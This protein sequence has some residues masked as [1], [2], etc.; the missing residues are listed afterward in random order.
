MSDD[1]SLTSKIKT[2]EDREDLRNKVPKNV[3]VVGIVKIPH[4][5]VKRLER[6]RQPST[7]MWGTSWIDNSPLPVMEVETKKPQP[8]I[9]RDDDRL[10]TLDDTSP[11]LT[12]LVGFLLWGALITLFRE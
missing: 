3:K 10:I 11:L 4:I 5:P 7:R 2:M 12:V 9:K 1:K 8:K 6:R